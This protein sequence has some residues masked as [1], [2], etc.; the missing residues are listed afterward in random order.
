[1]LRGY[2]FGLTLFFCLYFLTTLSGQVSTE[3]EKVLIETPK[4][5]DR[6]VAAVLARGG[7]VTHQFKYVDAI[8]AEIPIAS[9]QA[10]RSLVGATKMYK[11]VE[12]PRPK[13]IQPTAGRTVL[14][15]QVSAVITS[16]SLVGQ[17]MTP[18]MLS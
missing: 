18:A 12:T 6:V 9:L 10:I 16:T 13:S 1:M 5:Y 2:R 7:K 17:A 11:D 15:K 3:V 4:P 14:G 8:S